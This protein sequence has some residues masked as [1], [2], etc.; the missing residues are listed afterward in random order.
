MQYKNGYFLSSNTST[1]LYDNAA[2]LI[3]EFKFH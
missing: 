1:L 2:K 3:T